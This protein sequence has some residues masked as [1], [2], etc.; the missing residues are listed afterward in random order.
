ME[1]KEKINVYKVASEV[2][3]VVKKSGKSML[4]IGGC[5]LISRAPDFIKKIK[6]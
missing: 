5:L 6:K 3:R 2:G 1:Q 4:V